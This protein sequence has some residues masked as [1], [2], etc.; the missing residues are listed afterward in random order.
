MVAAVSKTVRG[1]QSRVGSIPTLSAIFEEDAM[2]DFLKGIMGKLGGPNEIIEDF[3]GGLTNFMQ[4]EL[5]KITELA[6]QDQPES[7]YTLEEITKLYEYLQ[8]SKS[9][10]NLTSVERIKC[11]EQCRDMFTN[12]L[13]LGYADGSTETV[14]PTGP[15]TGKRIK[16]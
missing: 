15:H 16:S 4:E 6:K 7:G 14:Y 5:Q 1:N 10:E 3:M 13:K 2:D 9:V 8:D 12:G 11:A